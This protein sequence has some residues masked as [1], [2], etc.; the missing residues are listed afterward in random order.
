MPK[1]ARWSVK[2]SGKYPHH[3]HRSKRGRRPDM[4]NK[5]FSIRKKRLLEKIRLKE[6][7]DESR[8]I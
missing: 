5:M 2:Y 1:R 4:G 6:L 7:K 3:E 8:N